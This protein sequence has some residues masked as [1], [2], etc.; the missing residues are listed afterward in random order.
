MII[1]K[2]KENCEGGGPRD[3]QKEGLRGKWRHKE[4]NRQSEKPLTY[5]YIE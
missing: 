3:S 4:N 1:L 2:K 5:D